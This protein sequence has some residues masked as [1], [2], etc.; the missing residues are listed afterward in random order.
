MKRCKSKNHEK[1]T[2][3]ET[4][5]L[6][7][8]ALLCILAALVFFLRTPVCS[9]AETLWAQHQPWS[10]DVWPVHLRQRGHGWQ[11]IR[12]YGQTI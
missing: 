5:G 4:N 8:R 6:H 9:V 3:A 11:R 7:A 2:A 12:R 1:Q 10:A